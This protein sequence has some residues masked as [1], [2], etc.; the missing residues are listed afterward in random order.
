MHITYLHGHEAVL[1]TAGGVELRKRR[2]QGVHRVHLHLRLELL[3][4]GIGRVRVV[5]WASNQ[6][7]IC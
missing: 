3:N 2:L 6:Q 4:L 5:I 7:I 1:V